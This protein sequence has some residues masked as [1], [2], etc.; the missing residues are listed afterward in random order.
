MLCGTVAA[1]ASVCCGRS[2]GKMKKETDDED[3][4]K[5]REKE[6]EESAN[7]ARAATDAAAQRAKLPDPGEKRAFIFC[8]FLMKNEA[9]P[10]QARDK[11]LKQKIQAA[12]A[13][14]SHTELEELR[15]RAIEEGV[16]EE[17]LEEAIRTFAE[18][19]ENSGRKKLKVRG[20][21]GGG[22]RIQ[23]MKQA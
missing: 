7:E 20:G 15:R 18:K 6:E 9:L 8:F 10:R 17:A 21:G 4:R 14:V 23:G 13:C 5:R 1:L 3:R 2:C 19:Q 16:S 12:M 11:Q 22:I